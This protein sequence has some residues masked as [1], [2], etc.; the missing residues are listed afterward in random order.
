[1]R[2]EERANAHILGMNIHDALHPTVMP[3]VNFLDMPAP[4]SVTPP[5]F[6][7]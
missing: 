3:A 6:L 1:M 5:P 2:D 7:L 4:A